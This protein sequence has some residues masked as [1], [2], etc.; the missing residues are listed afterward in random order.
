[1]SRRRPPE[2][3]GPARAGVDAQAPLPEAACAAP[4]PCHERWPDVFE[5]RV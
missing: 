4:R 3:A 1:M 2:V 5:L